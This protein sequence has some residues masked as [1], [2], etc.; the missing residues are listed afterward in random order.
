[1]GIRTTLPAVVAV[2]AAGLPAAA[3]AADGAPACPAAA[4]C[5]DGQLADGTPYSFAKPS[6]W[7]GTVLVDLDFAAGG[8]SSGLTAS[9]LKHGY[10]VGGTTRTV[11]GWN[12]ARA[13]DNQAEALGRFE[14]AFG[15]ARYAIAEGR[16]MGGMVAA[17]VAQVHP[18][19]FDAAVPMCGGLG[20]AVGQWNQKLDTVFTLKTLLFRDTALPVT[21][22]PADVPGTQQQ[23][24][25]A[26]TSAQAT[27]AGRARIALAAAIGQVPGWGLAADGTPTPVPAPRDADGVEQGMFLAL[28][29][30]PL[31]YLGQAMSS[32]RA[33]EQLA[34]GN[35]SWN[36]GIDYARQLSTA[37][38]EQQ[39]AVR[40]LYARAGLDLGADLGRLAAEPRVA[41]DPAAVRYLEHGIVFTGD[42]RIPVLTVN[43]TG[44][45]ISTVAQQ[46]SYG[47]LVARAGNASLLRQT[48][49]QTAGHCTYTTGEQQAAID[50]MLTR[51]RSGHW[52]DTA[53]ETMNHLSTAADGGPGR[54]LPYVPPRFNRMYSTAA[55]S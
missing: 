31:P 17:G 45:Q 41:A 38:P 25:S 40:R 30:G 36:T 16:S 21:S 29:G 4:S 23:W 22:I 7:N 5:A 26:M 14:T 52:P 55:G 10:A 39:N 13:I 11:T 53:P 6:G 12:I 34:G 33:I 50:R 24:V 44:D 49:V 32:R 8:L 37:A 2:L 47:T 42:L 19:R 15:P 46:Q 20:G 9:L 18:D 54:Y 51:L 3:H 35:P 27:P 48:Y 1:M 43:G 28:A